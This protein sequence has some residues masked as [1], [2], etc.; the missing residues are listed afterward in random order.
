M[1]P[2][3]VLPVAR[4]KL[5]LFNCPFS[6]SVSREVYLKPEL[7][8]RSPGSVAQQSLSCKNTTA[9]VCGGKLSG[10]RSWRGCLR[11]LAIVP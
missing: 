7:A 4:L 1:C 2:L 6:E 9:V 3:S 10:V 8:G 11:H 5:Y